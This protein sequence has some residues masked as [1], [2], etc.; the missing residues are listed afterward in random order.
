MKY[1]FLLGIIF[2]I[3]ILIVALAQL[4]ILLKQRIQMRV[5][6]LLVLSS[7]S[8]F[9]GALYYKPDNFLAMHIFFLIS[10]VVCVILAYIFYEEEKKDK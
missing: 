7:I 2:G 10:G 5:S 6:L 1:I 3:T 4:I 9:V 8:A